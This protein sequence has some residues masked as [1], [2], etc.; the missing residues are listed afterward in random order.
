MIQ[1]IRYLFPSLLLFISIVSCLPTEENDNKKQEAAFDPVVAF[2]RELYKNQFDSILDKT[3]FNGVISIQKEAQVIYE[4]Y[5]GFENFEQKTPLD[6]ASIYAI[7]SVSKQFT[8]VLLLKLVDQNKLNL[9]D[10]ISKV[11]P[12]LQG[13]EFTTIII[14]QLLSHT[15][16]INDHTKSLSFKPGTDYL[17]SNKGFNIL[18][19][20]IER[21]GNQSYE[22]Q[23]QSLFESAGMSHSYAA[24]NFKGSNFA[25]AYIGSI[26]SPSK[27]PNMPLRLVDSSI[28]LA[29]GGIL[30]TTRDLH[31]WNQSLYE[32]TILSDSSLQAF[33]KPHVETDHYIL[34]TVG[35]GYGIMT[36][37]NNA[38][39]YMH[40]GYVKGSAS[41]LIYYP[42][43]KTSVIILC[44]LADERL[45][46]K[47]IFSIHKQVREF[48]D[49]VEQSLNNM[50]SQQKL[51]ARI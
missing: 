40:T 26:S 31:S 2:Q 1:K 50:Q 30:S 51:Q 21:V 16:G 7:A 9:T 18:G 34:G 35:Y 49:L 23:L 8:A 43:S 37:K 20:I 4:K 15:S 24:S 12:A 11:L 27:V 46:K 28:G 6:S 44:N 22:L 38:L 3:P 39:A 48:T 45:G 41:L 19:Q 47:S 33:T 13:P 17:Y 29:A 25:S 14:N 5:K 10:T 36:S 42:K 32:G